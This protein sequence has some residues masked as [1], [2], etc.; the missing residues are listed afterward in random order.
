MTTDGEPIVEVRGLDVATADGRPILSGIDLAIGR[1]RIV[2]VIGESG[3]GKST[4]VR[5]LLGAA[6]P[7]LRV[8]GSV[9]VRRG[10]STLDLFDAP[11]SAVRAVRSDTIAMLAQN[12]AASLT[13]T[14][15]IGAAIAERFP[16]GDRA[17]ASQR[18]AALLE[19]VQLPGDRSFLRRYP[20]ELSGGQA[21]RVAL[22][23]ALAG[24]PDVLL[25][26][27]P[28]TGLDVVIQAAVLDELERQQLRTPRAL[29]IV[30]HDLAVVAR[31][32]HEV[33]VMRN[34][35]IVEAGRRDA[36]L[37]RPA[38]EYTCALVEACPDH[39]L[40]GRRRDAPPDLDGQARPP[41]I[42]VRALAATDLRVTHPTASGAPVVAVDGVSIDVD[43]GECV[44]VVGA[45][46]SGKSTLARS[47]V[48]LHPLEAG[49]VTLGERVLPAALGR[50]AQSD[51]WS[52]QLIPQDPGGSLNPRRRVGRIVADVVR[53]RRPDADADA[54]ARQLFASVGLDPSVAE[55]RRTTLSGGE[56]QRV[57]IARALAA[58]PDVLICDEITS[59]LDVSVQAEVIDLLRS[60]ID[61]R[62]LGVLFITH[63]LGVMER[64]A[65]RV[66]VLAGGRVVETG[67]VEQ[68]LG[69]PTH[70]ATRQ[71]LAASPSL[72]RE[73]SR[74]PLG[75]APTPA[76]VG[77]RPLPG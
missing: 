1:H 47:L 20:H 42:A 2:G 57:A 67:T 23:R 28:T 59:A 32:A 46:G 15:R 73:L 39:Q 63:D 17:T 14:M 58:E 13:P 22:A 6:A 61:E 44:A 4:L 8:N 65:D 33:V 48:G 10:T 35:V 62:D 34:G 70:P 16:R 64:I 18:A 66:V 36:V 72:S 21:Q 53:R 43:R 26:D 75:D 68:V 74:P 27:E 37:S 69:C 40:Q 11:R 30:S 56:C 52:I 54:A 77:Q 31:L 50:R 49:W 55:R 45:S 51:R 60:L 71:L 24:E 5:C 38:H 9:S 19:S 76:A 3:S 29:L 41:G 12:P 25:L 7:G